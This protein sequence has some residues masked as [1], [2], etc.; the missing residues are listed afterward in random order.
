MTFGD[1]WGIRF[2]DVGNFYPS[3]ISDRNIFLLGISGYLGIVSWKIGRKCHRESDE[4]VKAVISIE[5][6][7]LVRDLF[8][9]WRWLLH[10]YF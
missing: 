7:I 1:L 6:N 2:S 4:L 10:F 9:R 3:Y 5:A 8:K